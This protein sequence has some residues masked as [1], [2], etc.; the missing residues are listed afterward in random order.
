MLEMIIFKRFLTQIEFFTAILIWSC[1]MQCCSSSCDLML[2]SSQNFPLILHH[3]CPIPSWPLPWL[4]D[5]QCW[6]HARN[7]AKFLTRSW[8]FD[9][10]IT[11]WSKHEA[12]PYF[13]DEASETQ[14]SKAVYRNSATIRE[15]EIQTRGVHPHPQVQPRHPSASPGNSS[16]ERWPNDPRDMCYHRERL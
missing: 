8:F 15:V 16:V 7:C 2:L 10:C 12:H 5:M 1:K 13:T 6:P 9:L 4:W 14:R 11:P 3:T